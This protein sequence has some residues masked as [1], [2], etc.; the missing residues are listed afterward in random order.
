ME[1]CCDLASLITQLHIDIKLGIEDQLPQ[2]TFH[3][4]HKNR[5]NVTLLHRADVKSTSSFIWQ[6]KA[7]TGLDWNPEPSDQ[8][9]N[10]PEEDW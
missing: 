10:P 6:V 7:N 8:P 3:F 1:P 4:Y 2:R 5:L 9:P